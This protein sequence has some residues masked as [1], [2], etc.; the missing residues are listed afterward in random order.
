M[1]HVSS[2]LDQLTEVIVGIAIVVPE[3]GR[4]ESWIDT[5]L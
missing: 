5:N 4:I 2:V 1:R 3:V